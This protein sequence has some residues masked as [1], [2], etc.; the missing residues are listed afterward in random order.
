M[1]DRKKRKKENVLPAIGL[2]G[3]C[4]IRTWMLPAIDEYVPNDVCLDSLDDDIP[5]NYI[6]Y[7]TFESL[8]NGPW[9]S[10]RIYS[11]YHVSLFLVF[12]RLGW[13]LC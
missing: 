6:S 8:Y 1:D 7:K 10:F 5:G 11:R 4:S 12:Q 9:N 2:V 13:G 3:V